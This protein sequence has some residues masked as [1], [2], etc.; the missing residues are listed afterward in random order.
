MNIKNVILL[1]SV[2][3]VTNLYA[4][5]TSS[6]YAG[7]KISKTKL[8]YDNINFE[9]PRIDDLRSGNDDQSQNSWSILVG[10]E[11]NQLP[12]RVE[13]EYGRIRSETFTSYWNPFVNYQKITTKADYLM[14]NALYDYK[15]KYLTLFAGAGLGMAKVKSEAEQEFSG[16]FD[17]KTNNNFAYSLIAGVS[18]PITKKLD[19]ELSYR[20]MDLGQADTGRSK[21]GL[22]DE[23]FKGDL[24]ANQIS[25][26]LRFKF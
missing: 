14:L 26:G 25:L 11:L 24:K 10:K 2:L 4:N 15:T 7:M 8:E 12:M 21:F 6:Y 9:N 1:I 22:R 19:I 16:D 17:S 5:E 13:L 23:Q 18:K 20:Y 3:F